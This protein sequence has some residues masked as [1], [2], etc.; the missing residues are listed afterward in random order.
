[1]DGPIATIFCVLMEKC[2]FKITAEYFALELSNT[3]LLSTECGIRLLLL[4]GGSSRLEDTEEMIAIDSK[5]MKVNLAN[6]TLV[7]FAYSRPD[8][9]RVCQL[10][11]HVDTV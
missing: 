4:N 11:F 6:P 9:H 7:L 3:D 8:R 10:D 5:R 2:W 1:M